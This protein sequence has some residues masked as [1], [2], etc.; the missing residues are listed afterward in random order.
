MNNFKFEKF[1]GV[2]NQ[3]EVKIPESAGKQI[4][5]IFLGGGIKEIIRYISSTRS[6]LSIL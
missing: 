1:N 6:K 5:G 2:R 3:C 4:S